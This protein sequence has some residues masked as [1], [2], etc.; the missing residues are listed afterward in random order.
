[1]ICSK[2]IIN[3]VKSLC[4]IN[5]NMVQNKNKSKEKKLYKSLK[6]N[7]VITINS[8]QEFLL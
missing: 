8:A 1:M 3:S 2:N 7:N 5:R 4:S 6:N